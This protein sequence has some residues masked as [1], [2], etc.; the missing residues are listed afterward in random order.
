MDRV[1]STM[2]KRTNHKK[3]EKTRIH[4]LR[5]RPGK[6]SNKIF[7]IWLGET[8]LI[9]SPYRELWTAKN[10]Y[11]NCQPKVAELDDF[12]LIWNCFAD[13]E[14]PWLLS[15]I[16][17]QRNPYS[18]YCSACSYW[19]NFQLFYSLICF[20]FSTKYISLLKFLQKGSESTARVENLFAV[21]LD[22]LKAVEEF[23]IYG[24]SHG[25]VAA[26]NVLIEH[27]VY[28]RVTIS[29]CVICDI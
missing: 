3:V 17:S 22:V 23:H 11:E 7:S 19:T 5:Y 27:D 21:I 13:I 25:D 14:F 6:R 15:L 28:C 10:N 8:I 18:L 20:A 9:F 16:F 4:D 12:G 26:H 2:P 24:V 29:G 1:L